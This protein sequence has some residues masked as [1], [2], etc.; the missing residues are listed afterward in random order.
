MWTLCRGTLGFCP[1]PVK[2]QAWPDWRQFEHG[3]ALSQRTWYSRQPLLDG[4]SQP[5]TLAVETEGAR[6]TLRSRHKSHYGASAIVQ[7]FRVRSFQS[8]LLLQ[9]L[10]RIPWSLEARMSQGVTKTRRLDV[11]GPGNQLQVVVTG[12]DFYIGARGDRA[13]MPD[14]K[15][16]SARTPT[17]TGQGRDGL[18]RSCR[19]SE[20]L[21]I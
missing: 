17:F 15:S 4:T 6:L 19:G 2:T 21:R 14:Q 10:G 13:G 20:R 9:L 5:R 8:W 7:G 16:V 3:S 1:A 12:S 18:I 11:L